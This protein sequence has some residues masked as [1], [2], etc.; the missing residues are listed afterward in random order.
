MASILQ[1]RF[2]ILEVIGAQRTISDDLTWSHRGAAQ[3]FDDSNLAV[4]DRDRIAD[5]D[6]KHAGVN[7]VST[8]SKDVDLRPLLPAVLQEKFGLLE[9]IMTRNRTTDELTGTKRRAVTGLD[10]SDLT[11]RDAC[12]LDK[13]NLEQTRM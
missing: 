4:S 10:D 3:R 11:L 5:L 8:G 12:L 9:I 7:I 2:T 1:E 6:L 13:L